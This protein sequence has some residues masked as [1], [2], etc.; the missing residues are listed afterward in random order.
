MVVQVSGTEPFTVRIASSGA[1]GVDHEV[2][3][4]LSRF[5]SKLAMRAHWV[6]MK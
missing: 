6:R 1:T 5:G 3:V 2:A 4:P